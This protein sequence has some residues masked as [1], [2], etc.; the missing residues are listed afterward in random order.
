MSRR[1]RKG[2]Q[3]ISKIIPGTGE[4]STIATPFADV[5][6]MDVSPDDTSLLASPLHAGARSRE[7]WTVALNRVASARLGELAAD[8][9][10]WSPNGKE[11]V[12]MKGHEIWICSAQGAK[13]RKLAAVKGRPFSPRFSPD[14]QR[15]RFSSSDVETNTSALWEVGSD[16]SNLHELMPGWNKTHTLCCGVWSKDGKSYVFQA[17]QQFANDHHDVVG[18]A[19]SRRRAGSN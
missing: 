3:V 19:H 14:G 4:Q 9:A 2:H 1:R 6:A 18:F 13:A 7:L 5:R 8:D 16:G 12:S 15:I 17:V 11:L 10:A